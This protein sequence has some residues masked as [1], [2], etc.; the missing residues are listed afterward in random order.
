MNPDKSRKRKYLIESYN[1]AWMTQFETIKKNLKQVFGEKALAIKHI[2][3]TSIPGMKAKPLIDVLVTIATYEPFLLEK[4]MM[5]K[6]GYE[7]GENYIAPDSF[8]F[9]KTIDSDQKIENIHVCIENSPKAIQFITTRD[10]LRTHP[11]R[12]LLY[13]NLKDALHKEFP[14]DYPAY[15]K[16]KQEFID[17]SERLTQEWLKNKN[18]D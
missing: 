8:I 4:E 9:Y 6:L 15:R 3:S 7:W 11:E 14:D 2:G 13:S 12:A 18:N 1:P 10:Y 17:E 16:G 5:V